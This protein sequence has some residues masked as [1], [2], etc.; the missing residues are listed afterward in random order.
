MARLLII[1]A[2]IALVIWL[3]RSYRK[4]LNRP[5]QKPAAGGEDMVRCAQCGVHLPKSESI[6][7]RGEFFC[8]DEHRRQHQG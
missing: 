1:V 2:G 7:S 8:S 4:V 3:L 6:T 5:T